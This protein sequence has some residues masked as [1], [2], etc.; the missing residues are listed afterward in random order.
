MRTASLI[1]I[2][3]IALP[4]LAFATPDSLYIK[5]HLHLQKNLAAKLN[6]VAQHLPEEEQHHAHHEWAHYL[7][8]PHPSVATLEQYFNESAQ[9][10]KV[11]VQL[12]KAIGQV[13]NNWTQIGPSIDKGWGIMHLV[14]NN[15]CNTLREAAKLLHVPEQTL[16]D[17]ARQNIRGAAALLREYYRQATKNKTSK[18]IFKPAVSQVSFGEGLGE[19]WY[20]ATKKFSGLLTE[21]LQTIQANRY[22]SV[23]TDGAHSTTLWGEEIVLPKN[24]VLSL[25]FSENETDAAGGSRSGDYGPAIS[26]FTSCNYSSTRNHTIDTYVNHWIG[27]G[28]AAG[29]VSWFQNCNAQASAHFVINNS[30]TIYQ[31]VPVSSTAW[32][33]GAAGYPYNNGRSI[34][35]EHEATVANP[36]LWNSTAMLQ[37]SAEMSCYFCDLYNIPTNQNI[38]SPGICGHN[39]M[40]GTNTSCPGTIPWSNWFSYFNTGNCSAPVAVQPPNDYCGNATALTVY[41]NTCGAVTTGDVNGATQS[42]AP[43]L[44]DGYTASNANDVWYT[45]VATASTHQ[46]TVIPSGGM[47]AVIDLRS[48]C[49]GTTIDCADDGG[50]EGSTE[51]LIATGLTTGTTYY[52]RV[53]DYTGSAIPPT[54]TGF[55]ICITTPCTD[56]VKPIINGTATICSGQSSTL[57][58][59]N[60]CNGCNFIWSNGSTGTQTTVSASGTYRV[61]ATNACGSI[62]SD[63]FLFNVNQTPQPIINNLSN[64]YCLASSN[65]TLSASPAGGIFSGNGIAGNIFSPAIAGAGTHAI[66]YSISQ[67]GCTG[68]ITQSTT[69]SANPLVQ[70]S[71]TDSNTFC[72]GNSVTL[73]A[74]QGSSYTWS[75]GATTQSITVNYPASFNVT[76][77]NPGG[78]NASVSAQSPITTSFLPNPV[79]NAGNDTTVFTGDTVVLGGNPTA[80]GSVSPY[81]YIW[82]PASGLSSSNTAN[83]AAVTAAATLYSVTVTD[84]N[85]CTATD[86]VLLNVTAP[87]IYTIPQSNFYFGPAAATDSFYV[88]AENTCAAWNLLSCNWI[89]I[90]SPALPHSGDAIVVFS[91]LQN[92]DTASRSCT[93]DLTGTDYV[94]IFQ[95]GVVNDPCLPPMEAPIIQQNFCELSTP[96]LPGVSYQWFLNGNLISNAN[97]RFYTVNQSGYYSVQVADSNFCTAMSADVYVV[98][99][100]CTGL[101]SGDAAAGQTEFTPIARNVWSIHTTAQ[102]S[103]KN[104]YVYDMAGKLIQQ[105]QHPSIINLGH[106]SAG[107]YLCVLEDATGKLVFRKLCVQ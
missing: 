106:V 88:D 104:C 57:S 32:H 75:T 54:T 49:P 87:C 92:T 44:C 47:D 21:E 73:T 64:A 79:A 58:I 46:I 40:P 14:Q 18:P 102:Q 42:A 5:G 80:S 78:C 30:G 90:I 61:S 17:D 13:E 33:C 1:I 28:T 101:S 59:T 39:S 105:S 16:K 2:L 56:P 89:Q 93:I 3:F 82:N 91:V 62:S 48:G 85:G 4:A 66:T 43:T 69:V 72:Q 34:G 41:G 98:H 37:A 19:R 68:S 26:S 10:F 55:S 53:Y 99:P 11:P 50:G 107:L 103:I 81:S 31:V 94:N 77:T 71:S 12:L 20:A 51:T 8:Q 25:P 95:E 6:L 96:L 38:T 83:P 29:A 9:E 67:N 35:V 52:V 76:V 23:I 100:A 70:I 45:F 27:T 84:A 74:T 24:P 86:N 22:F 15:Y 65:A 7:N 36:G 63:P 60:P 97:T